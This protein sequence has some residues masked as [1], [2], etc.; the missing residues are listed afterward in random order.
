MRGRGTL[1]ALALLAGCASEPAPQTVLVW[2][3]PGATRDDLTRT[4]Q[5]CHEAIDETRAQRKRIEAE[6]RAGDFLKCMQD[7]GWTWTVTDR[8]E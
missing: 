3:K 4:R 2:Q 7:K 8:R 6:V 1:L 5:A